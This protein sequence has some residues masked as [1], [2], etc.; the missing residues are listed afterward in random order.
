MKTGVEPGASAQPERRLM[1]AL[2]EG[3]VSDFEKYATVSNGR[4]RRL[5]VEAN[6]W[7][8]STAAGRPL[9]FENVCQALEL[10]PSFVR[11][12]LQRWLVERRREPATSRTVLRFPFRRVNGSPHGI[13]PAS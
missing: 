4:G 7:I 13:V 11:E 10:D 1:L 9:D 2:L 3:A 8:A 12:G 5:F 6:A